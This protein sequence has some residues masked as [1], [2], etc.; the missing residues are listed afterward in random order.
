[1]SKIGKSG[2]LKEISAEAQEAIKKRERD[3][4]L[5]A[6]R[7]QRA[8]RLSMWCSSITDGQVIAKRL[9]Q[10]ADAALASWLKSRIV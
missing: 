3:Q 9:K 8:I 4:M 10:N 7:Y 5:A 2:D 1:M 6:I